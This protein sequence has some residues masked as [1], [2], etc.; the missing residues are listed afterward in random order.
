MNETLQR[1]LTDQT[2]PILAG[3]RQNLMLNRCCDES[4]ADA[5]TRLERTGLIDRLLVPVGTDPR[6]VANAAAFMEMPE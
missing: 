5:F 1:I 3:I 6:P 4:A 2:D